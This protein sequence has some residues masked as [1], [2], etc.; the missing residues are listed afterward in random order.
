MCATNVNVRG[1][2]NQKKLFPV[3]SANA[4]IFHVIDTWVCSARDLKRESVL[5]VLVRASQAGLAMLAI[6]VLQTPLVLHPTLKL[7][8]QF[9]LVMELAN[10]EH[11]DAIQ[12]K[13][14]DS[15]ESSAK[16]APHV[17]EDVPNSRIAFNVKCTRQAH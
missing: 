17:R 13:K 7:S 12:M 2:L 3:N 5:V 4:T 10:V 1:E 15:L 9:V 11:A 6:A 8:Q 16:N 14:E